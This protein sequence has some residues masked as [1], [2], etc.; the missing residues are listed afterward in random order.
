MTDSPLANWNGFMMYLS[1]IKVPVLDR[2]FMFGDSVY[3]VIRV[4]HGRLFREDEHLLRLAA[5]MQSLEICNIELELI[6]QR[7][8][9]LLLNSSVAEGLAYIQVTRGEA[10]KRSHAFP[11]G[12]SPNVLIYID[13][14]DDPY[15]TGRTQG[16][17]AV[18]YPDLRWK[19]NDIKVTSLIANCMAA[20]FAAL[21]HC[22]EA[23]L[24]SPDGLISEGSHTSVF[25][26]RAGKLVLTP[27]SQNVLP[28]ITKALVTELAKT[29]GIEIER[30]R[31]SKDEIW[32]LDE[33][34]LTGTPEEIVPIV[35]VD[36]RA[37]GTGTVGPIVVKLQ[38]EFS[39]F[40]RQHIGEQLF[41]D[42]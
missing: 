3:E 7:L 16:V 19:R 24:V 13:H 2:G 29:A 37:V 28:G 9:E 20:S 21:H 35:K 14:F 18:T 40:V 11:G 22:P 39:R 42:K 10:T 6:K 31:V 36:D 33:L 1:E 8:H 17:S 25:A 34:F 30:S 15:S 12:L 41:V 5:S 32:D 27:D 4:Y 23:I 26:A 38:A